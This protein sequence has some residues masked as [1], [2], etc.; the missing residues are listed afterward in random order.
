MLTPNANNVADWLR[1]QLALVS[2]QI[3]GLYLFGSV[4]RGAADPGDCDVLVL[5]PSDPDSAGRR[6]LKARLA[7]AEEDFPE[8]FGIPLSVILLGDREYQSLRW[9]KKKGRD[10]SLVRISMCP[11]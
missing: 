4:T 8:A 1:R 7:I 3:V 10:K 6:A 5:T 9:F 2:D 11:T